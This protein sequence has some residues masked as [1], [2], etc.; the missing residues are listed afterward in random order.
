VPELIYFPV[1]AAALGAGQV[2]WTASGKV[3]ADPIWLVPGADGRTYLVGND[4][5]TYTPDRLPMITP[6]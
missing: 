6:G 3:P 1:D 4:G 5:H 2:M